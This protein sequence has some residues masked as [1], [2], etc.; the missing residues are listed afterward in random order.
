MP[1][2]RLCLI[3]GKRFATLVVSR[4]PQTLVQPYSTSHRHIKYHPRH[5]ILWNPDL[6]LGL[7]SSR[8][9][10]VAEFVIRRQCSA[11]TYN[12]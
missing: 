11:E 12:T 2:V 1:G 6:P 9:S 10:T 4:A 3:T 8:A 7:Q 5:S